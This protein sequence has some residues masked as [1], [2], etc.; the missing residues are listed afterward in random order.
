MDCGSA[1]ISSRIIVAIANIKRF[2][3]FHPSAF[4]SSI[5]TQNSERNIRIVLL[6]QM[7]YSLCGMRDERRMRGP[8]MPSSIPGSVMSG[9]ADHDD[10]ERVERVLIIAV[11]SY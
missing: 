5:K 9:S 2:S 1:R 7:P 4:R 11:V 8:I 10:H 6:R 3:S